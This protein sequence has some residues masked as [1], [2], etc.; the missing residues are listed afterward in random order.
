MNNFH[1]ALIEDDL[2]WASTIQRW[3]EDDG[4]KVTHFP[5]GG[6]FMA[7]ARPGKY[8]LLIV[9]WMLPDTGG[10]EIVQWARVHLG[11]ELGILF[12]TMRDSEQEIAYILK[13]G[14]DDYLV[15]PLRQA[16]FLARVNV[17]ARRLS[18]RQRQEQ[19]LSCGELKL[20]VPGRMAFVAGA[21]VTL[22]SKEFD[23]AV[24]FLRQ[25]GELVS[26]EFLLKTIWGQRSPSDTR[27]IDTHVNRLKKKLGPDF[28][29]EWSIASVHG[30]GYRLEPVVPASALAHGA[31][32]A[33]G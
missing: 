27:T 19:I 9:D 31:S 6:P 13:Q 18:L 8:D 23:L 22:A 25:P 4:F 17:M 26:R 20:D 29:R 24:A 12:A 33:R 5:L 11:W 1:V 15:K 30:L 16:E 7:Q 10:D 32:A 28:T 2:H 3:L 21:P 14:A